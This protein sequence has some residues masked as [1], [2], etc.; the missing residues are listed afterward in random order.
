MNILQIK[1]FVSLKKFVYTISLILIILAAFYLR[2]AAIGSKYIN[3]DDP[4]LAYRIA[5]YFKDNL[6][7]PKNDTLRA[8]PYG[9]NWFMGGQH[10]MWFYVT[11]MFAIL[12]KQLGFSTLVAMHFYPPFFG[13]L[14]VLLMFFVVK[15]IFENKKIALLAALFLALLPANIYRTNSA[16]ADKEPIAAFFMMLGMLFLIK[17]VKKFNWKFSLFAGIS[18]ALMGMTWGGISPIIMTLAAFSL[19]MIFLNQFSPDFTYTYLITSLTTIGLIFGTKIGHIDPLA[20]YV[21]C[22]AI[23]IILLQILEAKLKLFAKLRFIDYNKRFGTYTLLIGLLSILLLAILYKP[24]GN[25]IFPYIYQIKEPMFPRGDVVATT[26]AENRPTEPQ[27][28]LLQLGVGYSVRTGLLNFFSPIVFSIFG[29]VIFLWNGIFKK[30][31]L[32]FVVLLATWFFLMLILGIG[33]VR[34]LFLTSFPVAIIAAYALYY[35]L[36]KTW[37]I[38]ISKYE[39]GKAIAIIVVCLTLGLSILAGYRFGRAMKPSM[40][41]N[42]EQAL[43]WV[44][45][46][47]APTDVI[48]SWWDYGYIIQKIAERPTYVDPG[49]PNVKNDITLINS[50]CRNQ[51]VAKLFTST[52]ETEY[53]DWIKSLNIKYIIH[54]MAMI[55]KY[56]AV[57]KIASWGEHI[58]SILIIPY[59]GSRAVGGQIVHQFG[60]IWLIQKDNQSLIP[61]LVQGNQIVNISKICTADE[62]ITVDPNGLPGCVFPAAD[63]IA[64]IGL[65]CKEN[66]GCEFYDLTNTLFVSMWFRDAKDLKHFKLV[67]KNPEVKIF[68]V[69]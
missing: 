51:Q 8:Y 43:L 2:S 13:A 59:T 46:N 1:E 32:K 49:Q 54:D 15:E 56:S 36:E 69:I 67:Y 65:R 22:L 63:A 26:V 23:V 58:D 14:T 10:L 31:Q 12:F 3:A 37:P 16:F 39:I 66:I 5:D 11:G 21:N 7:I 18:F 29:I 27:E 48:L 9:W 30:I 47:S 60:N 6:T 68:E 44:K 50:T 24:L 55:G 38:K 17:S 33:A 62:I 53:L 4:Y 64:Y 34:L 41:E 20:L 28:L 35:I 61:V 45:N 42:W 25:K 19:L 57:S 40:S 52:N